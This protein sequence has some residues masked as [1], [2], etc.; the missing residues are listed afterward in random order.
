MSSIIISLL[1]FMS[2][3]NWSRSYWRKWR[4]CRNW[5][6]GIGKIKE[7]AVTGVVFI[8]EIEGFVAIELGVTDEIKG[9]VVIEEGGIGELETWTVIGIFCKSFQLCF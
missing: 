3:N 8:D 4:G 2:C 9:V 1:R 7:A 5:N 6:G